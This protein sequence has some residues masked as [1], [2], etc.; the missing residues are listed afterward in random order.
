MNLRVVIIEDD[1]IIQMFLENII[2]SMGCTV[3]GFADNCEDGISLIQTEN[4]D[5][6]LLDIGIKGNIDG[7]ETAKKIKSTFNT[8]IIFVT[9][10]SD[11]NTIERAKETNPVHIIFKP[12]D[13]DMLRKDL[14]KVCQEL[15]VK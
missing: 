6:I 1:F 14:G 3:R 15:M 9:G 7:I 10:N 11:K 2:E 5:V 13:E 8:P 12:I 4:P